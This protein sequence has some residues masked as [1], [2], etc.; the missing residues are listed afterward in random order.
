MQSP[1][2]ANNFW[3]PDYASGI[4]RLARQ[5]RLSLGQLHELRQY[6]VNQVKI[7]HSHGDALDDLALKSYAIDSAFR[8]SRGQ[9][10]VSGLR[11]VSGR[12]IYEE[13][14]E[15]DM[16]QVFKQ[17]T[18]N[19]GKELTLHRETAAN[20]EIK[21]VE[22]LTE[23][24]KGY[25]PRVS[26]I[27]SL[28]L[29]LVTEY[30]NLYKD[31]ELAK[32]EYN[33]MSR[34]GEFQK[35]NEP[36]LGSEDNVDTAT[37]APVVL[38]SEES[39]EPQVSSHKDIN[40]ILD[41]YGL[42][43]PLLLVGG[44]RFEES[45]DFVDFL[46]TLVSSVPTIK[47]KISLPGYSDDIFS[48]EDF[49]E[50]IQKCR[51]RGFLPVRANVERLGQRLL[52]MK[53][54]TGT[55]FFA[56]RFKSEGM[57]FEWSNITRDILSMDES[58]FVSKEDDSFQPTKARLDEAFNSMAAS[59]T[60][61]LNGVLKS[62]TSSLNKSKYTDKSLRDAETAYNEAYDALQLQKH[63]LEC[64][65][66]TS[67]SQLEEFEKLKIDTIFKSLRDLQDIILAHTKS[68]SL[69]VES[70]SEQESS[71]FAPS[72]MQHEYLKSLD[73]FSCGIYF[74][75]LVSPSLAT[76]G[77]SNIAALNTNFQN[78]KL[79]FNLYKD[80][81]LQLKV[82][83]VDSHAELLHQSVPL[84]LYRLVEFLNK[85]TYEELQK[86]WLSPI[87]HKDAW[88]V[89]D[90][91]IS[92]AQEYS[93][94]NLLKRADENTVDRTIVQGILKKVEHL[95][96][97]RL[98]SFLKQW[99][100]EVNDSIIPS[101][102]YDSLVKHYRAKGPS[103][104]IPKILGA[105]PRSNLSSLLYITDHIMSVFGL[106]MF[107]ESESYSEA[108]NEVASSLNLASTIAVVPFL[109]LIMRPSVLKNLTGLKPSLTVYNQVLCDLFDLEVRTKLN[110]Q[111]I[112]LEKQFAQKQEQK[113]KIFDK[114]ITGA[115]ARSTSV[116]SETAISS[117]DAN[118]Q[119]PNKKNVVLSLVLPKTP[120][121]LGD[122]ENFSLRPFR[123]G[124]TPR[125]TPSSS[126]VHLP[127]NIREEAI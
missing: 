16:D 35:I 80:I 95:E 12:N 121:S 113:R 57:W 100:L 58:S 29:D 55:G 88:L 23:F 110:E 26:S 40:S 64:L 60:K 31:I 123:T 103:A 5:L 76:T 68:L 104:D 108:V 59:T 45:A 97:P 46:N 70:F 34:M 1:H 47:R 78:I 52:D 120:K 54:I 124:T 8:Q 32:T 10:Q 66:L 77:S 36:S 18:Q 87:N 13:E 3:S 49:S 122:S 48:S 106:T 94:D 43:M 7:Y 72:L 67:S 96:L 85:S 118:L 51:I 61:K 2:F 126:P 84:F 111:L 19:S 98:I 38:A 24:L 30:G 9:R 92:V 27:V 112:S 53:L 44:V 39:L 56:K 6:V 102:V 25:E 37:V 89:K 42:V 75:S 20:I 116:N 69:L 119:T 86:Q 117:L 125:P 63:M 105:I 4:E 71:F 21:V 14:T 62:V 81:P 15:P 109:H 50:S 82:S 79:N 127:S 74:P 28:L 17:F 22:P 83:D 33:S 101:T 90:G 65:I 73:N 99:L 93:Q 11:K 41:S 115:R 91:I 107:T 114:Q